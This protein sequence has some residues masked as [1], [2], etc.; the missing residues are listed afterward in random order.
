[1]CQICAKNSLITDLKGISTLY[2]AKM[3]V[4]ILPS[5]GCITGSNPVR[6]TI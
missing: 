6:A 3:K 1:M 4:T 5:Q 2:I